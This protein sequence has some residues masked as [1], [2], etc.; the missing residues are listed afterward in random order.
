MKSSL[1]EKL[2]TFVIAEIGHNHQGNLESA[3]AL[4]RAAASSGASAAKFQKRNNKTLFTP[5]LYNQTYNSEN[6]FG[7]TYGSHRDF[8]EFGF[9]E[10]KQCIDESK[11]L[12][13]AFLNIK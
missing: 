13:I 1:L 11:K 5:E 12:G 3:L 7:S 4:I 6:A 2:E 10:Y 8:L 9:E